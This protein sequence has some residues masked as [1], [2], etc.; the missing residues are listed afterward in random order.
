MVLDDYLS[1]GAFLRGGADKRNKRSL[2]SPG[3]T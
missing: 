1:V 2:P 3:A